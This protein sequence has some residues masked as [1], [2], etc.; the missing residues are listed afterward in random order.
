MSGGSLA[1]LFLSLGFNADKLTESVTIKNVENLEGM[2][3]F[4]LEN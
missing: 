1:K 4:E 3:N 2:L